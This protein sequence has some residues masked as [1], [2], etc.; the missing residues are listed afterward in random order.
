[1][2]KIILLTLAALSCTP[3][4]DKFTSDTAATGGGGS[5]GSS[6]PTGPVPLWGTN[7]TVNTMLKDGN[8]L[9]V[10][11][12]FTSVSPNTGGGAALDTSTGITPTGVIPRTINGTVNA[13]VP[14][15][16]GGWYIGGN[17][18]KV[19]ADT[20]NRIAR[21]NS[22]GSLNSWAPEATGGTQVNALALSGNTMYV[23]GDFTL[24]GGQARNRLAAVDTST[25]LATAFNPTVSTGAVNKLLLSGTTLYVTLN[26]ASVS[27]GGQTRSFLAAV[28]TTTNTNNTTSWNPNSNNSINAMVIS[29]TTLYVGGFFTTI[30]GQ[31]R[32]RI[33]AIDTGTGNATTW[34]PNCNTGILV[35]ALSGT[36]LY[37]GSGNSFTIGGQSRTGVAALDTT[38]DTNNATAWNPS[39]GG[40]QVN[41]LAVSGTTLYVGGMFGTIGGQNRQSIAAL[42][43]TVNTNNALS[44]NPQAM[45]SNFS[46]CAYYSGA[47]S[48]TCSVSVLAISGS[49]IYAGGN[50]DFIGLVTRNNI[51]ALDLTTGAPT[52]FDANASSTVR[53]LAKVGD[54]LY[55]G[56]D[57]STIGGQARNS[58][59]A[60]NTT[61]D[62]PTAWDP[63]GSSFNGVYALL[64][65]GTTMYATGNFSTIGG[66]TRNRIAALD[67]TVI[68]NNA[69]AWNPNAPAAV[70]A[71]VLSGT[72]LYAGGAFTGLGGQ[73]RAR[74]AALDTTINTNMATTWNPGVSTGQVN[75]LALSGTTLYVGLSATATTIGGQVRNYIAAVSTTTDTNNATTW[76]P[77][78]NNT[79]NALALS[80][81]TL[82]A[83]GVFTTIGGQ[84]RNRIAAL[85]TTV[86]TNNATAWNPNVSSGSVVNTIVVGNGV[87]Y[88]AGTFTTIGGQARSNIAALNT[89]DGAAY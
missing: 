86:D 78:A 47:W 39:F 82:Y 81:T 10:G 48:G 49:T 9:Y 34:N 15:G 36:T 8:T 2:K 60:F 54:T 1:M 84:T 63:N 53:A 33:A 21:I 16:S 35:L 3:Y 38:I 5:G 66:Q 83:G 20:R 7:G 89:T 42:D 4:G 55:V 41:S 44:W 67:T 59:A 46:G 57:F 73:V 74:I 24:I 69:T 61:T 6:G 37:V 88:A 12:N 58:I 80:G 50:F 25:G 43:T 70:N 76:N 14:D 18:T 72:T 85:D 75:A 56:G 77:N 68:T 65:S 23:G 22:D 51:A 64:L 45:E 11:G 79:V 13:V 62:S 40:T 71:L 27:I 31:A 26:S 29:G 17:F 28:D 19:G 52:S 32:N 87:V 30:G